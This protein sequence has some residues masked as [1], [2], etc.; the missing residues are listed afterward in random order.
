MYERRIL[1]TSLSKASSFSSVFF[2]DQDLESCIQSYVNELI[3]LLKAKIYYTS[4]NIKDKYN[5][6]LRGALNDKGI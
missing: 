1:R 2:R 5:T 4:L 6:A 3:C